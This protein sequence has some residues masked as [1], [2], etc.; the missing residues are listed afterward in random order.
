M[1]DSGC[2]PNFVS[3]ALAEKNSLP[4]LRKNIEITVNGFNESRQYLTNVVGIDLHIG[5]KV[6]N[7][8]AVCVPELRTKLS[9]K[10]LEKIVS[11]F[12][13]KGYTLADDMLNCNC[14]EISDIGFILGTNN[15]D[16]MVEQ[17]VAFGRENEQSVFSMTTAGILLMGSS[18]KLLSN[19]PYLPEYRPPTWHPFLTNLVASTASLDCVENSEQLCEVFDINNVVID[20]NAPVN[21]DKL[22]EA[23]TEILDKQCIDCL[24]YEQKFYPEDSIEVNNELVN[25]AIDNTT[26]AE[27]GRLIMPLFWR[28]DTCHLLGSNLNLAKKILDANFKKLSKNKDRL[29]MVDQ[30]FKD[31][32]SQGVIDR[33]HDLNSFI[34]SH[35]EYSVLPHMPVFRLNRSTTKCRVVFLSNLVQSDNRN[36]S[37]YSHNQCM[38]SG[39]PLNP[40]ITTAVTN[41][42]F[43]EKLLIYDVTK[44]FLQVAL[45]E[46]D[47]NKLLF[48]WYEDVEKENFSVIAYRNLRLPFG[49]R[50][51]PTILMLA[52][53]KILCL[54]AADDSFKMKEFKKLLY[55]MLYMD[56]GGYSGSSEE[57]CWAYG[58]LQAVFA[59]YKFELQQI[60]TN[61][62]K[63]QS[64]IDS[65][66]PEDEKTSSSV[67]LLGLHWNRDTDTL[68]PGEINLDTTANTK[69]KVLKTI[70]SQY[71]VFNIQGPCLNRS[72]LFMHGIQC[73][74]SL[75]WDTVLPDKL[76]RDW[77]N[78]TKQANNS[79]PLEIRRF[80]GNREDNFE[81]IAF[82]DASKTMYAAVVYLKNL[83]DNTVSFVGA[84]NRIVNSQ[85]KLKS[86]PTLELQAITLGIDMLHD[87]REELCG[88]NCVVPIRIIACHLYTDSTISLHW[89]KS[90]NVNFDKMQKQSIFVK[91]R[92][93][94]IVR[95]CETFPV[96]FRFVATNFNPADCMTRAVSH[97]QLIK[98]DYLEGPTFLQEERDDV[99]DL[100]ITVPNPDCCNVSNNEVTL[101]AATPFEP[102]VRVEKFSQFSKIVRIYYNVLKFVNKLKFKFKSKNPKSDHLVCRDDD[103][104]FKMGWKIALREDQAIWFESV[105]SFL[106]YG[107]NSSRDMPDLVGRLNLILDDDGLLRVKSKFSRWKDH[108]NFAFPVLLSKDSL[109]TKLIIHELHSANA[110][111]G[112]YSLL[113]ELR[114][115]Y[116]VQCVFSTVRKVLKE[117]VTCRRVNARPIAINQSSYR[118]FRCDPPRRPF[119]F[120]FIDHLGGFNISSNNSKCKIWLL[121]ITCLWSRAVNI[122]VCKDL[123]MPS[124]LR[125]LQFH[126]SEYGLPSRVYSDLGSQIVSG[127]NV[128]TDFLKDS[129]A[130]RYLRENGVK[131]EGFDQYFKGNSSLGSLVEVCVKF[132]KKLIYGSIRNN[133]LELFDFQLLIAQVKCLLNKRPIAFQ[134][135]L[136][137]TDNSDIP[138][139]ITPELL[140]KGRETIVM[141][142]IPAVHP[143]PDDDPDW[144]EQI[145][146]TDPL[147]QEFAKLRV[148]NKRLVELYN[149]EFLKRLID[150]AVDKKDRY[151]PVRHHGLLKGDIVLLKDK[152]LKCFQ[153]PMAVV[154][155]VVTNENN[156]VT[157]IIAMKGKSREIVRR[158]ASSVIPLLSPNIENEEEPA[159]EDY[160]K[161]SSSCNRVK[162]KAAVLA[163]KRLRKE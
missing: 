6:W 81:L 109:L 40:K 155:D 13:L 16:V 78:I 98:T 55:S 18:E 111:I 83:R 153:Y 60:V 73:D 161:E 52:L 72:R 126:V 61:D 123:T 75:G 25:Y 129:E 1:K 118:D 39:P 159:E 163:R 120:V 154:R 146:R 147:R 132:A 96:T 89:L 141:N 15:S 56:N 38:H 101:T 49:L 142:V 34:E 58:K 28:S 152:H 74:K 33:I 124:F 53:Y 149:D 91:N 114:K 21:V 115:T 67:K 30:V 160:R 41:L 122:V 77:S 131:F 139:P 65:N 151:K 94:H 71:D 35:P 64:L 116:W 17:Q 70:A 143:D 86:V 158:H 157:G 133:R 51:S 4:I 50:C 59:P 12:K 46:V 31:Q 100:V 26:R 19:L 5:G 54:D 138:S 88:N 23:A 79:P 80:C 110:H 150:Q 68:S 92:L 9:I 117:C 66:K 127:G 45:R 10:N 48:L 99:A 104:L 76:Q 44:A 3:A 62:H 102:L 106:R 156:E 27:D 119:D 29:H 90:Y 37:A 125:A 63:L 57:V 82:S 14:N 20:S 93:E 95:K 107:G 112:C 135:A 108:P 130:Q 47:A 2:Q 42:R 24:G 144:N 128:V 162:R 85:L 103:E 136:R 134:E 148:V 84:K 137:E 43:G 113:A 87:T 22:H 8:E 11:G 140:L 97:K 36:Q 32:E 69:R 7:L 145:G 105:L 121:M